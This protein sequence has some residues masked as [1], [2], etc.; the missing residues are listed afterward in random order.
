MTLASPSYLPAWF[1]SDAN[2][3]SSST[4]REGPDPHTAR[5][6]VN[7][8]RADVVIEPGGDG[9]LERLRDESHRGWLQEAAQRGA[10]VASVC[11]VARLLAA[12]GL[13]HQRP[14]TTYHD[15]FD[16]VAALDPRPNHARVSDG[17]TTGRSSRTQASPPA[18]TW[19]CISSDAP[20]PVS[21]HTRSKMRSST[22]RRP[23]RGLPDHD[24][25][26]PRRR[27]DE[28]VAHPVGVARTCDRTRS[29]HLNDN[30]S[31]RP[32]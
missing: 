15:A 32:P 26:V 6:E 8:P 23:R 3:E 24:R 31:R 12:A 25:A 7:I 10:I 9:S 2:L 29:I 22:A 5:G 17:S 21:A 13:L 28:H 16:S 19:P 27:G 14:F 11:T 1:A 20:P 4:L 30:H 18:S